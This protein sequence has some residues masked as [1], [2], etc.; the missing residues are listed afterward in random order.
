MDNMINNYWEREFKVSSV[1]RL[2]LS[3]QHL[4]PLV[5]CRKLPVCTIPITEFPKVTWP[6]AFMHTFKHDYKFDGREGVWRNPDKYCLALLQAGMGAFTPDFSTPLNLHEEF[7]RYNVLRSRIV[8]CMMEEYGIPVIPTL[9][10]WN[11]RSLDYTLEGLPAGSILAVSTVCVMKDEK[12]RQR[13]QKCILRACEMLSPPTLVVYGS[14]QGLDFGGV[15]V[16]NYPNDTY[17]WTCGH[18][19]TEVRC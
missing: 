19:A 15:D 3:R 7:C 4:P 6:G 8:G 9:Q 5:G 11:V 13:F 16:K 14:I 2:H 10:W 12:S 17:A 18:G 1:G